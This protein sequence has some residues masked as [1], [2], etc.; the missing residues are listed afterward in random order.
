MPTHHQAFALQLRHFN[1]F[2]SH[3]CA[4]VYSNK[5][6]KSTRS[7]CLPFIQLSTPCRESRQCCQQ[8]FKLRTEGLVSMDDA[9]ASVLSATNSAF[10]P[11]NECFAPSSSTEFETKIEGMESRLFHVEANP[12]CLGFQLKDSCEIIFSE[13]TNR[14]SHCRS[15]QGTYCNVRPSKA[16]EA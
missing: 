2:M 3:F 9:T 1:L 6:V 14:E 12:K 4:R 11:T 7:R 13:C 15:C 5:I 8:L 16:E 10:V